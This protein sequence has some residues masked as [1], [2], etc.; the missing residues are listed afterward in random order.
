[1]L[2]QKI[3]MYHIQQE[4]SILLQHT[5]EHLNVIPLKYCRSSRTKAPDCLLELFV[6]HFVQ[7]KAIEEYVGNVEADGARI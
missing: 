4:H 7:T 5:A 6:G 1:M 2:K 3:M